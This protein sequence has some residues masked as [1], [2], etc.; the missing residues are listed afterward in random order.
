M[1]RVEQQLQRDNP[2]IRGHYIEV[3]PGRD[4]DVFY[5]AGFWDVD[6]EYLQPGLSPT[7]EA[8]RL[9]LMFKPL[10]RCYEPP[11]LSSEDLRA[12]LLQIGTT[13]Y[14]QA[15]PKSQP[16]YRRSVQ[17]VAG[18]TEIELRRPPHFPAPTYGVSLGI[19]QTGA[20]PC[21]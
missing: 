19:F 11:T 3:E 18:R 14:R 13:V 17:S 5:R 8:C 12:A 6:I 20:N 2:E 4:R 7:H 10:G 15:D 1:A 21:R 9:A 16:A